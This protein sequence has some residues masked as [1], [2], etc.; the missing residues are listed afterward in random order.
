[1]AK[2]VRD[3]AAS[4]RA[5]LLALSKERSQLFDLLLTRYVHERLLYRLSNSKH[6]DRF[7]LKGAMLMTAWL[8]T[9]FRPT[10]DVDF[11]GFGDPEPDAMLDI[12]REV[13][14]VAEEDGAVFDASA[15]EVDRIRDELDYG[16]LR[17]K[18]NA[19]VG[20]A[21]TR[22]VVDIGFGDAVEAAETRASR[23]ARFVGTKTPRLSARDRYRREIPGYGYAWPRQQPH[24]GF[25]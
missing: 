1:M 18:T 13:C 8:D 23:V 19:H 21:R 10:R 5:R 17:I 20:A 14:S 11:L 16:G 3:M 6:R 12:F 4:V 2:P 9:G 22:V 25:L 7:V 15:L 24:E